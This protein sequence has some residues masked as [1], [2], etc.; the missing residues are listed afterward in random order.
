M[1]GIRNACI[2]FGV[3]GAAL[4]CTN[5]SVATPAPILQNP[6]DGNGDTTKQED[7]DLR[8]PISDDDSPYSSGD[9][10]P[11]DLESPSSIDRSMK[12][13]SNLDNYKIEKSI[14]GEQIGETE[15][16]P[17]DEYLEEDTK[18]WQQDYF[19]D[20]SKSQN[21]VQGEQGLI[22]EVNL[23]PNLIDKI[24]S[25]GIIDIQPRGSAE[26]TFK[27]DFNTVEN[28]AWD[29]RQQRTGQFKFDQKINLNVTGTI[30]DRIDIG[31]NYDTE[32]QFQFD[33]EVS[34]NYQGES[35]EIV[36][37]LELGNINF[38]VPGT[39]ID[40]SR[41]LFGVKSELQ[42]G[43]LRITSAI[44]QKRSEQ[45]SLTVQGG[46]QRQRFNI[47]ASD[48]DANR[49]FF[50]AQYFR[51][52]YNDA[53]SRLPVVNSQVQI[54]RVE[55]WVTNE[56]GNQQKTRNIVGFM[57]LGEPNP[58]N[59]KNGQFLT[60][61]NQPFPDN[62]ANNLYEELQSKPCFRD[63]QR[64]T[65]CL[66]GI[67][68]PDF[69][70]GKDYAKIDNARRLDRSDYDVNRKLGFISLNRSLNEDEVLAVAF[71]YQVNG[72]LY[73]VGEFGRQQNSD[74]N[75]PNVLFLKLL[76][77]FGPRTD[78]PIWDLMMKNVYSVG[79]YQIS[80]E[81][82][83][84]QVLYE[85]DESGGDLNYL[86]EPNFSDRS[87][88]QVMN[89]D[90]LNAK[91]EGYPDGRFDYIPNITVKPDNGRI[92]FPVLEPFGDH[93]RNQFKDPDSRK[94]NQYVYDALYDSTQFLAEQVTERDKFILAGRYQSSK[95][96]TVSLNAVDIPKNSVQVT[97]GGVKLQEGTDYTV[98]YTL[99]R[100][101][102]LNEQILSSGQAIEVSAESNQAFS[103]QQKTFIGNRF[104]YK[105]SENFNLG[106][107]FLYQNETPFT[108][109]TNI[110]NEPIANVI[111]GVDG[112]YSTESRFLTDLVDKIPLLDTKKESQISVQGEFAQII[113][114]HPNAIGEQGNSYLD[115][116]EGSETTI[117]LRVVRN[118][119]LASTPAKQPKVVEN[120]G[121]IS[122]YSYNYQRAK[123]AW[124][125]VD[126]LF[127]RNN[128]FTPDHIQRDQEMLSN[129]YMRQI[130]QNEVFPRRQNPQGVPN[131]VNSFDIAF[132]PNKRGPYNFN[133][134]E[135]KQNGELKNP[136]DK[137]GGIM[138]ALQQTDFQS[139]NIEYIEFWM[140]DPFI[141]DENRDGGEFY[142]NLGNISEDILK[143]GQMFYE[144]GLPE[145]G[146]IGP[147]Q[148]ETAWGYVPVTSPVNFS[149]ANNPDSRPN[150]DVGL[151]G[152]KND[153]EKQKFDSIFLDRL[154]QKYGENSE[155]YQQAVEDP[156]GDNYEYYRNDNHNEEEHNIIR[157]YQNF[158]NTEGNS[159]TPEQ[160]PNDYSNSAALKPDVEDL[161]NDYTLNSLEDYFQYRIELKPEKMEVGQNYI[162]DKQ[163][164]SV[165]LRN[166]NTEDVTWYQFR[167]PVKSF[168]KKV[169]EIENFT[170]IRFMRLFLT[171]FSDSIICRFA[172]MNL[173]RTD[174]RRYL[175]N[176][177]SLSSVVPQDPI[178]TSSF[179]ISTVN[180]EENS[181]R[182][183]IPYVLPPDI[184]REVQYNTSQLLEQNEQSLALSVQDL[185]DGDARAAFKRTSFN[186]RRYNRL[187]M[188]AHAEGRQD[189]NQLKDGDLWLFVRLGTD[190]SENYYEYAIP[191]QVTKG[192][193]NDRDKI[194]PEANQI[195]L[196]LK[197][198]FEAKLKR[199]K[200]SS[201]LQ[202]PFETKAKEGNGKITVVGRPD[203]SDVQ[204][205]MIGVWNPEK[206]ESRTNDNGLPKSGH[207]W[208]NELRV[209]DFKEDG[210]WAARGQA[211]AQLA[212]F[213]ELTLAGN[214]KTIGFGGL[215]QNI[216][217]RSQEDVR[218]FD[219]KSSF[220]LGKFFPANSGI[221]IPMFYSYSETIK[222][223]RYNPLNRD[224]LLDTKLEL[225]ESE[226][227]RDSIKQKVE[228]FRSR[229]TLS[230]NN[231]RK[232]RTGG[233]KTRPW[234]VENFSAT[235]SYKQRF[236]RN[237]DR[238]FDQ[239]DVY[240]GALNYDYS[241]QGKTVKPFQDLSNSNWLRP[242]TDFN[243]NYIP[244]SIG[245]RTEFRRLI[246]EYEFR[247][248]TADKAIQDRY[249]DKNF[250]NKRVYNLRWNLT[251]S[252]NLNYSATADA[253]IDEPRGP[254]DQ[255]ARD[256]IRRNLSNFG[257]PNRFQ[258]QVS[259]SYKVPL[260]KIPALDWTSL[261][262]NYDGSYRWE[263]APPKES[264]LGNTINN[265][266]EIS[267]NGQLQLRRLYNK[268]EFFKTVNRG[269]DNVERIKKK[270]LDEKIKN[271]EKLDKRED[272]S[273]GPKPSMEDVEVAE[274]LIN[275]A[276]IA[277]RGLMSVRN[278]N[279][280]YSI[281]RGTG[282][283]GFT[284]DPQ[285]LGQDV[286]QS[287]PSLPFVFGGQTDIDQRAVN[288]G[289]ITR[290]TGL[291]KPFTNNS[292]R[293][294]TGQALIEPLDGLRINVNF[295][296]RISEN[297]RKTIRYYPQR[298]V[299]DTAN[300]WST[301]S[302][303]VSYFTLPT[304]FT[305]ENE[306]GTSPIFEKFEDN[307]E[308]IAERQS[309]SD[310]IDPTTDFPKGYTPR[311][312]QVLI[313][314]FLAAYSGQDVNNVG[315][316]PFP[317]VPAPNWRLTYNGLGKLEIIEDLVDNV[318]L[319]HSYKS[320]YSVN[321]FQSEI[322]YD[323]NPDPN[324]IPNGED[325]FPKN[326]INRI[327]INESFSPLLGVDIS[328][329]NG[330]T[331]RIEYS[332]QRQLSFELTNNRLNEMVTSRFTVGAG[333][334]TSEFTL[335][336]RIDGQKQVLDNE[337][338]FRLDFSIRSNKNTVRR[339]DQDNP[340]P[341]SGQ[342]NI[343]IKPNIDYKINE[344]LNLRI[345][346]NRSI[347]RP[348]TTQSY[349][350]KNTQFGFSLRY[351]LGG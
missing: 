115:D 93:L 216:Q 162:K 2:I 139:N 40:G 207:V 268:V 231:V 179:E 61:T 291:N 14:G 7:E 109:K 69:N 306:D 127:Y 143:D 199:N 171:D 25:G 192:Q 219:F 234:D 72:E 133:V 266:Q 113:P 260:K 337:V 245:F 273:A 208:V 36:Q 11:F 153:Q 128:Q 310:V 76:K 209:S 8:Y 176:A 347:R 252:L 224:V 237:I 296:K 26:L 214:R 239:K 88:L 255:N 125:Q 116:F 152:L 43:R 190:F 309:E 228:D 102:I 312:Q 168:D 307:R 137:W 348:V 101:K 298:G 341:I 121:E 289:W 57:D 194:W 218:G 51:D 202:R 297:S 50:L 264:S 27:G 267:A 222:R 122:N 178:D 193:T 276:E 39:L 279:V 215:E 328:W 269:G 332:K 230:F 155:A 333:Y 141:Y 350:R 294:L 132:F 145:D 244:N 110:G 257:R 206:G 30:A 308:T 20:R 283:N 157:R 147:D 112:S 49:H 331:T 223:P 5:E 28:P 105:V 58:Y 280:N 173:V 287:A 22:P 317:D 323:E 95:G 303:S 163:V 151:D 156:A 21:F 284:P 250:T 182:N 138:R 205:L 80:Q 232:E 48:Y 305:G 295:N 77:S 274:T 84:C 220:N 180:I 65:Q 82:F 74:P 117:D 330:W 59:E 203:L 188:F 262:T 272:T 107:T 225:A 336:F 265:S 271:W 259:L 70:N 23:G 285:Y 140:M 197:E 248:N 34:I 120:G 129:H 52:N 6:V 184:Q 73:Q 131:N 19:K 99:G 32:S 315:L 351:T 319:N 29:Q 212:D 18:R 78:L 270:K 15:E 233:G 104:D 304:A 349:P 201:N 256:S 288:E 41:S 293:N 210:G 170:S 325:F 300:N 185:E 321:N 165:E 64:V 200:A 249:Y 3:F 240:N 160:W 335:P 111:W 322:R 10:H 235:Y 326:Q 292:Q 98:D 114:G 261:Q 144:N 166:G 92:I 301:G 334:R 119:Q 302:Y 340:E 343:E 86:P 181:N 241:F 313:P 31:I 9:R 263:A 243:F 54:K 108:Q 227:E 172:R 281:S 89:L 311:S 251:Q 1:G 13:D 258:Q 226:A 221:K 106:G 175:E 103:S 148:T 90:Q 4:A 134:D 159:P 17:L 299:Y 158:N 87:L 191:L 126:N 136:E 316:S 217:E 242:I 79:G 198:F 338:N 186:V 211:R 68:D 346:Y 213:A 60:G 56:R 100:V 96:K 130:K 164:S 123:I 146:Q 324:D 149:F 167:I 118:W 344:N 44:A 83:R 254:V 169:G 97:A 142:V 91:Q 247:N 187:E 38:P 196:P 71:E 327:Q 204:S 24:L 189:G 236:R 339:L 66:N 314:S 53:M 75:D 320:T 275:T 94:A 35:D 229:R 183:P 161:N 253:I 62:D 286:Q 195:D 16:V 37:N 154:A 277:S 329:T 278:V 282:V 345:F 174:W 124:Y 85:D 55:V 342:T 46:G 177:K 318:S 81:D 238:K 33:N 45:K 290:D 135:I 47:E 12:L 150:Q 42:F 67:S 63:Q 246:N